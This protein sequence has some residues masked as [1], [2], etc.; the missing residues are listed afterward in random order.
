MTKLGF[1][2]E[3]VKTYL[4]SALIV[5]NAETIEFLIEKCDINRI[6]KQLVLSRGK[7]ERIIFG[8]KQGLILDKETYDILKVSNHELFKQ[9]EEQV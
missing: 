4:K 8:L 9:L 1:S 7:F 2:D 5:E 6:F 3:K